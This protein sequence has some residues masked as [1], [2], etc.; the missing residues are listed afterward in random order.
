MPALPG[1]S[2]ST[3]TLHQNKFLRIIGDYPRR[4]KIT[5]I[6]KSLQIIPISMYIHH[7][8]VKFYIRS[9]KHNNPL[10][11]KT[12]LDPVTGKHKNLMYRFD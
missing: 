7:Q 2:P 9:A 3:L 1:T 4:T 8:L 5:E 10:L 6:H 12:E 11:S